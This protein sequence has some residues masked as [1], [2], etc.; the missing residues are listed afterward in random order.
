M[1]VETTTSKKATIQDL[2]LV[3]GKAEL[4]GG[5]IIHFMPTGYLPSR[6]GLLIV[7]SLEKHSRVL[8][9]GVAFPD[10]MGFA[11]P[12]LPSGRESFSPDASFYDGPLPSD[13]M[14]FAPGPPT[15]AVEVR[16]KTDYGPSA[17]SEMAAKRSDYF[18]AG[19]KV[20]W[21]V[22]PRDHCVRVY[23]TGAADRPETFT[24]G[25]QADA[26][27]AVSGWWM[28]VDEIFPDLER[29]GA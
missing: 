14:D 21:D 17:E 22:D 23:R 25:Q 27:P 19:T 20:V 1:G 11:V 10:N 13:D 7:L 3:P 16:S 29:N 24:K 9:H 4:V 2:A 15:F 6:I 5:K 28:A 8:R 12:E 18:Q 26:E